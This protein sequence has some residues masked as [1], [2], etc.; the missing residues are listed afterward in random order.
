MSDGSE[1]T[2]LDL[3]AGA[4]LTVLALGGQGMILAVERDRPLPAGGTGARWMILDGLD[5]DLS[6]RM[7]SQGRLPAAQIMIFPHSAKQIGNLTEWV[8]AVNPQAGL[9]PFLDDLGWPPGIELLRA[10]SHGWV[11]ISTDGAQ[12]WVRAER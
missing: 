7:I 1:G 11:D 2:R 8:R 5:D 6:R 4:R 3:G 12:M 9:W 10:D